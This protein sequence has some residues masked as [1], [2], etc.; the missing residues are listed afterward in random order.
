M[1]LLGLVTVLY[2]AEH[3]TDE[4]KQII[5]HQNERKDSRDYPVCTAGINV[6]GLLIDCF[7]INHPEPCIDDILFNALFDCT[8]ALE[9]IYCITMKLLDTTWDEMNASYM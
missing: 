7:R 4:W 2:F 3:H 9:E 1:G 5:D 6:T 8:G